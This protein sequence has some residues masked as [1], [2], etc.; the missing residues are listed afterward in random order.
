VAILYVAEIK[1][2]HPFTPDTQNPEVAQSILD[3]AVARHTFDV[4]AK[5]ATPT[6]VDSKLSDAHL[7]SLKRREGKGGRH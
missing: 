4:T 1:D 6:E 3:S 7:E 2:T 5:M